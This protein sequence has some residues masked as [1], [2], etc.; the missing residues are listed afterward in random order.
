[1]ER[2]EGGLYNPDQCC[3]DDEQVEYILGFWRSGNAHI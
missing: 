1:M 3:L 2:G